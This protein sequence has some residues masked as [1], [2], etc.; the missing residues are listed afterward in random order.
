[1]FRA[2]FPI[3]PRMLLALLALALFVAGCES[4]GP[5][6]AGAFTTV[7]IDPGHGAHDRGARAR[8]GL[9]EKDLALDTALRLRDCLEKRGFRVVMTRTTDVF[10]PLD[11]RVAISNRTPGAIF[12][13]VHYNWDRGRSGHG[14][15]TY[16]CSARSFRLARNVERELS[17]AYRT[18]DRGVKRGCWIRV[19]RKNAKPAIL[20]ECGFVSNSSDNAVAQN[21][22]GRQR[23]A[24]AIAR[25]IAAERSGRNP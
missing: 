6:G 12:V 16:A 7:V 4:Y 9:Y 22:A 23:I 18:I 24:E 19:L 21:P 25:G 20:V 17:C 1:M 13:S 11:T 3:F 10:I 2:S 14:V 5:I 8:F 15:E